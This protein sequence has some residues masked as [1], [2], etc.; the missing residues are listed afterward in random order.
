VDLLSSGQPM[1]Q[2]KLIIAPLAALFAAVIYVL[3]PLS[4][5]KYRLS[6]K[7]SAEYPF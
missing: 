2:E 4:Q 3:L 1:K 5:S 7:L 6:Q